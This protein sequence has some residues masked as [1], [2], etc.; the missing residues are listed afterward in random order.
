MKA[1]IYYSLSNRTKQ[2]IEQFD[3]DVFRIE[4]DIKI[5]KSFIGKMIVL[6]F[7]G[8]R[9]KSKPIK[10]LMIDLDRY[11]EITLATPVWAGKVSCFM[12]AFLEEYKIENKT[13]TLVA[14]CDGG[15]GGVMEDYKDYL[16]NCETISQ[17]YIKGEI[18]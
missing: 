8:I 13:V 12:R 9:K 3:G 2:I 15:P 11:E 6:G 18:Q 14:T 4:S 17:L 7:Y 1:I 10:K 16:V 5:P